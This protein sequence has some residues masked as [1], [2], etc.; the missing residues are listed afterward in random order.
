MADEAGHVLV[1]DDNRMN[2]LKLSISLEQQGHTVSLAEDGQQAL[3]LLANEPFDV[4][5]LDLIMPEM[6]G[7][8]VLEK[9][10][11]DPVLRDIPV[12]VISAVDELDSVVRC[13]EMGAEDY[14]P[15]SYDPVLLRARLGSSLQKKKLRDLEKIYLQ[16]EMML[17][18]SEKLITLGKL[19]AGM[20]HELNNPSAAAQRG[21]AQLQITFSKLQQ[22][23]LRLCRFKLSEAQLSMLADLDQTAQARAKKPVYLDALTR[24]DAERAL[25]DWMD[26]QK[27]ENAW[28]I[29][30]TLVSLGYQ[31]AELE[32]LLTG[33][34][35]EQFGA[36]IEW[37][38]ASA[39][40]YNLAEEISQGAGHISEIVKALKTYTYMDQAP[41]QTVDIHESLDNT[42][43][44]LRSKLASGVSV[45]RDFTA[46]L[47]NIEAY[48]S[49]LNQVWTNIIDNAIDAMHGQGEIVLRTSYAYPW[50]TVE[51]EDNGPGIPESVLPHVFDPFFT[52]KAV[53]KGTGL[54]LNISHS[55]I[56]QKHH[57]RLSVR[58]QPGKTCFEVR[59]PLRLS[60]EKE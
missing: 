24:S 4:V 41:V 56:V 53:G 59:L 18:Q 21:A 49:E 58:S 7:F 52:T 54:G 42:L 22:T 2:R 16:Q 48:G 9:I 47:P 17:R 20:A 36:A 3:A 26:E 50:V 27:V 40:I 38:N 46:D 44:I 29:A 34:S 19:S 14:L 12:I 1:V 35:S 23:Y 55:I 60:A 6:D 43:I 51:I 32:Q 31:Q 57:G 10:K 25:E 33:L 37:L 15:K 5:L 30:P 13:I 8:Q 45:K 11:G 28:E 39:T